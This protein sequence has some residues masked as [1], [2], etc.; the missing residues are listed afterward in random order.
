MQ[1][2][3]VSQSLKIKRDIVHDIQVYLRR[4]GFLEIAVAFFNK[5]LQRPIHFMQLH[6]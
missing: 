1:A 3:G 6:G 4:S 2:I 5:N